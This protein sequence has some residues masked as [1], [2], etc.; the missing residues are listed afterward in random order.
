MSNM[1]EDVLSVNSVILKYSAVGTTAQVYARFYSESGALIKT[2]GPFTGGGMSST[3][4]IV[5]WASPHDRLYTEIECIA[6]PGIVSR[7][8]T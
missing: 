1:P 6:G 4:A 3:G 8:T 7:S 5:S 2:A